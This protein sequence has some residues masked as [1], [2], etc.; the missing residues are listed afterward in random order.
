[1]LKEDVVLTPE[2]D[3]KEELL[4]PLLPE[5]NPRLEPTA[6]PLLGR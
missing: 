1:M 6:E 2:E 5:E 3:P 4:D